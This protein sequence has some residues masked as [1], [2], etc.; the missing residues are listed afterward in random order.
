MLSV[1]AMLAALLLFTGLL[2]ASTLAAMSGDTHLPLLRQYAQDIT[3]A[4]V[5]SGAW[6]GPAASSD[7]TQARALIDS[8]PAGLCA[9]AEVYAGD[10][11]TG[12]PVWA[13]ARGGCNQTIGTAWA[14]SWA[15]QVYRGN[16]TD[17][18]FE[19]VRVR[20]YPREG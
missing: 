10:A 5:H 8:L 19:W 17:Y 14:Q 7:D 11:P 4:G 18:S 12:A 1:E 2:L 9:Q 20:A 15:A 6:L 16:S 13:Y 3:A